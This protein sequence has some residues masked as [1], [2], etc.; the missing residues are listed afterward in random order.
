MIVRKN[1]E[2]AGEMEISEMKEY[3]ILF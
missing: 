1:T 2:G 3:Y